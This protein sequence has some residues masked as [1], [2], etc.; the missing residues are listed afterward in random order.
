MSAEAEVAQP[1]VQNG[2]PSRNVS[3]T[4]ADSSN[5]NSQSATPTQVIK[6]RCEGQLSIFPSLSLPCL[7]LANLVKF[8]RFLILVAEVYLF[9]LEYYQNPPG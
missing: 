6:V 4:T 3:N 1:L 7:N 9:L 8:F 5:S 2:Q